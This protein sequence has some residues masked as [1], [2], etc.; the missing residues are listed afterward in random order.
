MLLQQLE[1]RIVLDAAVNPTQDNPNDHAGNPTDP[2]QAVGLAGAGDH[3]LGAGDAAG[4]A[5]GNAG[6]APNFQ[7]RLS[8]CLART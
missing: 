2:G 8:T 5:G 4:S 3:A 6:L 1:E 7:R